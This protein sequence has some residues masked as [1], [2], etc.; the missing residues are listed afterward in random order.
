MSFPLGCPQIRDIAAETMKEG[1]VL[2][3]GRKQLYKDLN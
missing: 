1:K 2:V 3:E